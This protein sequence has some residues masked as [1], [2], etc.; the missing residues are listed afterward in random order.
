MC[1]LLQTIAVI[2]T[3]P[4]G[5]VHVGSKQTVRGLKNWC[6]YF[7]LMCIISYFLGVGAGVFANS[8]LYLS[9]DF[10]GLCIISMTGALG[11]YSSY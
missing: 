11:N 4:Y 3:V 9:T 6:C 8:W 7:F 5:V 10:D 1:T 2:A